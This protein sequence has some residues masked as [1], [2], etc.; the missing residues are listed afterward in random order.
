MLG[1]TDVWLEAGKLPNP[2]NH[3][4]LDGGFSVTVS[5]V[6]YF[7]QLVVI[8]FLM[9]HAHFMVAG[10][11]VVGGPDQFS[12]AYEMLR[13]DPPNSEELLVRGYG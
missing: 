8:V 5:M 3:A 9:C 12:G 11:L 4:I 7:S 1:P 6:Q 2:V 13:L 10:D